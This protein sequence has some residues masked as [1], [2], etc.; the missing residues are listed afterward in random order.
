MSLHLGID[1]GTTKIAALVLDAETG[2]CPAVEEVAN[3]ARL[4][5][6]PGRSEWSAERLVAAAIAAARGALARVD[7]RRVAGVGV[8]GQMHGVVLV[9]RGLRPLGPFVGWQDERCNGPGGGHPSTIA[10]MT[11]LADPAALDATGCRLAAGFLGATLFWLSHHGGLPSGVTAAFIP[12]YLVARLVDR[13][14]VADPTDAAG[15]G[16]F[17]VV[18][19]RWSESLLASLGLPRSVLPEVLPT[20]AVVGKLARA[21][22]AALGLRPGLPVT[23]A[24]GDN[25]ASFLGS[26]GEPER[27]VL[28][29]VGTGGQV[30]ATTESFVRPGAIET[31]PYLGGSYL[32]VGAELAGGSAYAL[33]ADFVRRVGSDVLGVEASVDVYAALGRLAAAVPPGSDGVRCDPRFLGTRSD[34]GRR[35]GFS[36]LSPDTFGPGHLARALLEGVADTYFGLYGEMLGAGLRRRSRLVGSGNGVR[37]NRL[38]AEILAGRF[39][40]PVARPWQLEEAAL[41]AAMVSAVGVGELDGFGSAGRLVAYDGA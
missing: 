39:G 1:V 18:A 9:G 19:G 30:S 17:D 23:N 31:R 35:G 3:D 24:L 36:G 33:L 40:L 28:V 32:L 34:P 8:T 15:S 38:L 16:L 7:A 14:P 26:V 27:D 25:Q 37:R 29:N 4:P 10:W 22:A 5:A 41:G 13:P 6:A 11:T 20:G 2:R 21:S 12:D